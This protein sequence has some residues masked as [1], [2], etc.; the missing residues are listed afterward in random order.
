MTQIIDISVTKNGFEPNTLQVRVD[1]EVR[2]R[3]KR[4]YVSTC[5]TSIE[6]QGIIPRTRLPLGE[7]TE[8]VFTPHHIGHFRFG[9]S[10]NQHIG[11]ALVVEG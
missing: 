6:A 2:L 11:G 9:C 5:A 8:V 3:V 10:M 7:T 1:E 4:V